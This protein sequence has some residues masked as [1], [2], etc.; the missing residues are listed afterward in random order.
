MEFRALLL[1]ADSYASS[2]VRGE[3]TC[4]VTSGIVI[5]DVRKCYG[6]PLPMRLRFTIVPDVLFVCLYA[7]R[8]LYRLDCYSCG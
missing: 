1:G 5:R 4:R 3:S 6:V 2:A 8:L 7:R